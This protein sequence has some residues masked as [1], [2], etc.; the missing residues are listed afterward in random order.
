[1]LHY[2]YLA[3]LMKEAKEPTTIFKAENEKS[4]KRNKNS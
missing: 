4:N 3:N 1:M 2:S